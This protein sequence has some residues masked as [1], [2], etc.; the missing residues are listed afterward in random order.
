MGVAAAIVHRAYF[1]PN[2]FFDTICGGR[3]R[4]LL[5]IYF[6]CSSTPLP[7]KAVN[8]RRLYCDCNSRLACQHCCKW[9]T[10]TQ[11]SSMSEMVFGANFR[12]ATHFIG[13]LCLCPLALTANFL[14]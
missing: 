9:C 3:K 10:S 12:C 7:E 4:S 14:L 1:A 11:E 13:I 8:E 5:K 6:A 2:P